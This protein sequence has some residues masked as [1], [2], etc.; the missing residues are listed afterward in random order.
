MLRGDVDFDLDFVFGGHGVAGNKRLEDERGQQLQDQQRAEAVEQVFGEAGENR[1]CRSRFHAFDCAGLPSWCQWDWRHQGHVS[2]CDN[3]LAVVAGRSS[4]LYKGGSDCFHIRPI[5][6][7]RLGCGGPHPGKTP[8][9]GRTQK[10]A[11]GRSS[12]VRECVGAGRSGRWKQ[13]DEEQRF[14]KMTFALVV[15]SARFRADVRNR[16]TWRG[17]KQESRHT[18]AIARIRRAQAP[19]HRQTD[20]GQNRVNKK[21]STL[22]PVAGICF[23]SNSRKG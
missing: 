22:H 3:W 12:G 8:G 9:A 11:E 4:V 5:R 21:I 13:G 23:N 6:L 20:A 16:E 10:G 15:E 17:Q 7:K 18:T 2:T 14:F 19:H 1:A